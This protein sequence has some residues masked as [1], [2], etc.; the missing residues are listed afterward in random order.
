M[1]SKAEVCAALLG[2]GFATHQLVAIA[3][4]SI[5]IAYQSKIDG[6]KKEFERAKRSFD[7]NIQCA[8]YDLVHNTCE[9]LVV[10]QLYDLT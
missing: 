1:V 4:G 7:R 8:T 9:S 3:I 5:K 10:V 2:P 6:L